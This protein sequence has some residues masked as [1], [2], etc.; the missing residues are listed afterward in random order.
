LQQVAAI[1][2]L[3]WVAQGMRSVFYPDALASQEMAHAWE[4]GRT[5]IVLGLWAIG[6]LL[7]CAKTFSWYKRGT[8]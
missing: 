8:T 6:G 5:A 4:P 2:P 1:F 7:L 3:K